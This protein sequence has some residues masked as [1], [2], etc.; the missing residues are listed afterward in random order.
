MQLSRKR[1][2]R[3]ANADVYQLA[4][5][6]LSDPDQRYYTV[7]EYSPSGLFSLRIVG[8]DGRVESRGHYWYNITFT[9]RE[10]KI[11]LSRYLR[12]E[13]MPDIE[14]K[15]WEVLLDLWE[16]RLKKLDRKRS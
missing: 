11:L 16:K 1:Y 4:D 9:P 8:D 12:T 3:D 5:R 13:K 14:K 10:I 15:L 2:E 7:V 6:D